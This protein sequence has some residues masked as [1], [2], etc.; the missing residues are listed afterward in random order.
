MR[1]VGASTLSEARGKRSGGTRQDA[2]QN[3]KG[4]KV[5]EER[6]ERAPVPQVP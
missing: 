4:V 5:L 3:R 6:V 1:P 2:E